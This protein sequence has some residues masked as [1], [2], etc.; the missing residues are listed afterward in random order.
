V[1][2][3]PCRLPRRAQQVRPGDELFEEVAVTFHPCS[4]R[5]C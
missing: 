4:G 3:A 1:P 5:A 2:L